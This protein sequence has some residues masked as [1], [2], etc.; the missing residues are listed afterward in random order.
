LFADIIGH[1]KDSMLFNKTIFLLEITGNKFNPVDSTQI[2]STGQFF[3]SSKNYPLGYYQLAINDTNRLDIILNP[4]EKNVVMDFKDARLQHGIEVK[5]SK[6]NQ[7]LWYYKGISKEVYDFQKYAAI[8][9]SQLSPS[10]SKSLAVLNAQEDSLLHRKKLL[11]DS[12][13][14]ANP[15]TFFAISAQSSVPEKKVA[16]QEYFNTLD[17]NNSAL[18]RTYVFPSRIMDYLQ[19]YTTYDEQGFRNSIDTILFRAKI[20]NEVY[21]FCL[22]FLLELFDR[23][24]PD[25]IFQYLV[26]QYLLADGCSD[27]SVNASI[28]KKAELYKKLQVGNIAPEIILSDSANNK[29]ALSAISKEEIFTV[30]FFWSSH[31]SYCHEDILY[32]KTIYPSFKNKNIEIFA[33]SLDEEKHSWALAIKENK[34]DWVNVSELKGWNSDVVSLYKVHKTPSYYLIDKNRKILFRSSDIV[35]VEKFINE[36]N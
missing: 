9:K 8:I 3:F 33:V 16:K 13:V 29:I 20:N 12:L 1:V 6:E 36:K 34:M 19:N 17:F 10:D 27:N 23:V 15:K 32:L 11:L 21:E 28:S 35:S 31:C 26:E 5:E 18:L 2:S 22:N 24:G 7:L 4:N 30:I 25:I 14:K